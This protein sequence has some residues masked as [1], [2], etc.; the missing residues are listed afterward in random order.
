[1][2]GLIQDKIDKDESKSIISHEN[3]GNAG[4]VKFCQAVT[5]TGRPCKNRVRY[6]ISTCYIHRNQVF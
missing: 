4:K 6:G 2:A 5:K 3:E 1:M